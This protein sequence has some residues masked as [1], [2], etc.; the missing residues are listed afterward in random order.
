ML[1][2]DP[3]LLSNTSESP[4]REAVERGYRALRFEDS[5]ERKFEIFY[6]EAHL[7]RVRLA[8]FL[9]IVLFAFF[10]FIDL[11][12]LPARV[13]MWTVAIRLGLVIPTYIAAL[14]ITYRVQW[15]AHLRTAVLVASIVTGLGTV[16]VIGAA[17]R[18][19]FQIPYEGILLVALFIYLIVCLQWWR[20]LVTNMLTLFAFIVM[21]LMYQTDPQARLY[22]IIFMLAANAV[23]A[24]GGYFL[25]YSTRTTYL[26]NALLHDLAEHDGL[27]G[28]Y[29]RRTLNNHLDRVWR[30]AVRDGRELAAA[31][32]DIDFFKRYNDRYGHG[33]GDVALKA[34][35][36][37]AG[38]QARRP[39]DLA[40]RYGG[41]EFVIVWFHPIENE[42]PNMGENL[43]KAVAALAMPHETS[44]SGTLSISVGIAMMRPVPGQSPAELLDTA[45]MALY[46]AKERGRNRVVILKVPSEANSAVAADAVPV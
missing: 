31:M 42:L 32:I 12:T 7:E 36:H 1:Y 20:A 26:V 13:S 37:A 8:G 22:Q 30:Q 34:V 44:E 4:Y 19:G 6:T 11:A 17:L 10:V 21:E 40:A 43:L 41:E 5:L 46:Q 29:N 38:G 28:L 25:E 9:G 14:T 39:L 23:G 24:Y 18:Q 27:T 3:E 35:A 2:I 45:D 16:A 15:R 33:Q